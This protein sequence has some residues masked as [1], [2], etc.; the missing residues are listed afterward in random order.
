MP[1]QPVVRPGKGMTKVRTVHDASSKGKKEALSLNEVLLKGPLLVS[2]LCGIL[3]R[4]RLTKIL[5]TA[6]VEK[7]FLQ[8]GLH[9]DQRDAVRFIWVRDVKLAAESNNLRIFRFARV[10]FGVISSP[11]LLN[12]TIRYHLDKEKTE[13]REEIKRGIYVNNV[14]LSATDA[15]TAVEKSQETRRIFKDARMN[16][17]EFRSNHQDVLTALGEDPEQT[18][19][20]GSLLG[21]AWNLRSDELSFPTKKHDGSVWNKRQFLA[22]VAGF[23]YPLGLF[24]PAIMPFKVFLQ[25]L[26]SKQYA[27]DEPFE[28]EEQQRADVL[29]NQFQDESPKLRRLISLGAKWKEKEL[30]IFADASKE[31]YA[32]V[33]YLRTWD[34]KGYHTGLVMSKSRVPPK[35]GITIPRLELL[36]VLISTRLLRLLEE[37]LSHEGP[38]YIWSDSQ[39]V[40]HWIARSTTVDRFVDNRLIEIRACPAQ[41]RYVGSA[42]NPADLATRGTT[43]E[44]LMRCAQWRNGPPFLQGD[45][46]LWPEWTLTQSLV[47]MTAGVKQPELTELI[48]CRRFSDLS[49]L[50]KTK[51]HILRVLKRMMHNITIH[52]V[53]NMWRDVESKGPIQR[54]EVETVTNLLVKQKQ[55]R[56]Q[57]EMDVSRENLNTFKDEHGLIR[58]QGR[59]QTANLTAEQKSPILLPKSSPLT[60]LIILDSHQRVGHMG[61]SA[62]LAEFRQRFWIPKGRS[63]VKHVLGRYCMPCRRWNARS[64][65]SPTFPPLPSSRTQEARPFQHSG[66][67]YFGPINVKDEKGR[68]KMWIA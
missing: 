22:Y 47:T 31:A 38:V 21:I 10:P 27:W 26:W 49:K 67:D 9:T 52:L 6:D 50:T 66:L 48:D 18:E 7:T 16:L 39:A 17:R 19:S 14:F 65:Q 15:S 51:I 57:E 2:S 25:H 59:L 62:T 56:A 28:W 61:T 41:F 20:E 36:A 24:T 53:Q 40:L 64:F 58:R 3:L 23:Y 12:A 54:M 55:R 44:T 30:H 33:A 8:L 11:F 68:K 60:K 1:H 34:E 45:M 5:I 46:E 29:V 43:I 4:A 63:V 35:K 13:L 37:Q 42:N 32:A